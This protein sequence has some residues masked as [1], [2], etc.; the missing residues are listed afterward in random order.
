MYLRI[1]QN[2]N[3]LERGITREEISTR[4]PHVSLPT[5]DPEKIEVKNPANGFKQIFVRVNNVAKPSDTGTVKYIEVDP[6]LNAEDGKWYQTWSQRVYNGT[7]IEARKEALKAEL[8]AYRYQREC[9]GINVG[10]II[11]RTDRDSQA[12][13]TSVYIIASNNPNY[14][15][16]WKGANGWSLLTAQQVIAIGN[17]VFAHVQKCFN[18]EEVT[19]QKIVAGTVTTVE[20]MQAEFDT[21]YN[22]A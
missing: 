6:V 4:Y 11:V 17:L 5:N 18:A 3:I 2:N 16:N 9:E 20:N 19:E 10:G 22:N 1:S 13:L 21:A 7:E 8:A 15:V 12:K 14:S